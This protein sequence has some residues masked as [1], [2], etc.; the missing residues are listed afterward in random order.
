[1]DENPGCERCAGSTRYEGRISLPTQMI[2]R[3]TVCGHQMW[4]QSNPPM[5]QPQDQP[6]PQQ[7]QQPQ[8][9]DEKKD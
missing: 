8:P 7:Q 4:M 5:A 2:Y 3:C 6:Q 9:D 1:M